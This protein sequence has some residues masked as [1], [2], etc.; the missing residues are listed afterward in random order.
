MACHMSTPL[1]NAL[2]L[3]KPHSGRE[4]ASRAWGCQ[5]P[6]RLAGANNASISGGWS[7]TDWVQGTSPASKQCLTDA[8]GRQSPTRPFPSPCPS[9][10]PITAAENPHSFRC[11]DRRPHSSF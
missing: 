7:I 5:A 10:Q 1:G 8:Q 2:G 4:F 11:R 3:R 6:P 9:P